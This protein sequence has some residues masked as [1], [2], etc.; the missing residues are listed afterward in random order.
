MNA[1]FFLPWLFFSLLSLAA[2]GA[3]FVWG[4]RSGQFSKA[5]RARF[6]PLWAYIPEKKAEGE[7]TASPVKGM[8]ERAAE[9]GGPCCSGK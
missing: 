6:L 4:R 5:G 9:G 7:S 2:G 3:F 8:P 1:S